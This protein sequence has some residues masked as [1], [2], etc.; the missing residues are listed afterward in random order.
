MKTA[1][2]ISP[3]MT[4]ALSV[5]KIPPATVTTSQMARIAPRIVPMT[6]PMSPVC[7]R[8][9]WQPAAAPARGGPW[10]RLAGLAGRRLVTGGHSLAGA[11]HVVTAGLPGPA[12]T[13]GPTRWLHGGTSPRRGTGDWLT[14]VGRPLSRC[15]ISPRPEKRA[16]CLSF[17]APTF[18]ES[19][20]VLAS[21]FGGYGRAETGQLP[22]YVCGS[23]PWTSQGPPAGGL[24]SALGRMPA[25]L[26]SLWMWSPACGLGERFSGGAP[27]GAPLLAGRWGRVRLRLGVGRAGRRWRAA[28]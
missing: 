2:A 6:R 17:G 7:A 12:G 23:S 20:L 11:G 27:S 13:S 22:G 9:S 4:N 24:R 8:R 19:R 14:K 25:E 15:V 21:R 3:M 10:G 1:I 5:A 26:E 16:H 28:P 18:A